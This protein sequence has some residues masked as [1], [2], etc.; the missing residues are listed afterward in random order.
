MTSQ[1]LYLNNSGHR[2][3]FE[4]PQYMKFALYIEKKFYKIRRADFYEAFG[5]FVTINFR[6]N[7]NKYSG[8]ARDT[9]THETGEPIID[10][11][12]CRKF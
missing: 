3:I 7:G 9:E 8:F 11:E 10:L 5:N 12:R 2:W 4:D 6:H 1:I